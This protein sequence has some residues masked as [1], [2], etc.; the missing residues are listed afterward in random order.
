MYFALTSSLLIFT[1]LSFAIRYRISF[2]LETQHLQTRTQAHTYYTQKVFYIKTNADKLEETIQRKRE[3]V[4]Y[5]NG[6]LQSK[7]QAGV[8]AA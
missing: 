4:G 2:Q 6:V 5:L 1:W 8:S 3:N 7:I